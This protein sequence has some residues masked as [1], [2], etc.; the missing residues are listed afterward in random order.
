MMCSLQNYKH[1]GSQ[2]CFHSPIDNLELYQLSFLNNNLSEISN[3]K[4]KVYV[5]YFHGS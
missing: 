1:L 5:S 2:V 4:V 3:F